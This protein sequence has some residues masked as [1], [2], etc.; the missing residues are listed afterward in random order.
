MEK[1]WLNFVLEFPGTCNRCPYQACACEFKYETFCN[2]CPYCILHILHIASIA[3]CIY[4]ILHIFLFVYIHIRLVRV[5]SSMK[6][7]APFVTVVFG[8]T[9]SSVA[10]NENSDIRLPFGSIYKII[11]I[12]ESTNNRRLCIIGLKYL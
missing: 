8:L 6:L 9:N 2:R 4:C 7:F 12:C 3:C 1:F 10:R 5:N 11:L